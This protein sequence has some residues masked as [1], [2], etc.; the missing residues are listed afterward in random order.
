MKWLFALAFALV[1]SACTTTTKPTNNFSIGLVTSG[2]Y[3]FI[4][5][6]AKTYAWHPDSG[7]T[8][9]D[10]DVSKKTIRHVFNDAISQSLAEKGY[11]RVSL[12]QQPDFIVG[13]GVA[14][15]SALNDQDLYEKTQL[16]TGIP[17]SD[18]NGSEEKGTI[19]IAMYNYPLMELK[20]KSLAQGA[21]AP[22]LDPEKNED[23]IKTYVDRMLKEMPVVK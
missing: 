19:Y 20:W 2:D 18:F 4:R 7:K 12:K 6:G 9:V 15:E 8:Y 5:S 13:Y 17:A 10:K 11:M 23:R 14:V 22:E 16:S 1:L 3:Q 21:S